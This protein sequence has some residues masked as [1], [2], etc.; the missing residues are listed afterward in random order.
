MNPFDSG[1]VSAYRGFDL[2][3]SP[4]CPPD[5]AFMMNE[6]TIVVASFVP[7]FFKLYEFDE[8]IEVY[9]QHVLNKLYRHIENT[10]NNKFKELL[11]IG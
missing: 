4:H 3:E 2:I 9:K 1:L 7:F 8:A 6:H 10:I 11:H 5:K